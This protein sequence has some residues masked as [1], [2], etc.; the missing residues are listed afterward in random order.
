MQR[1]QLSFT[2]KSA[3]SHLRFV[4]SLKAKQTSFDKEIEQ[5]KKIAAKKG[6]SKVIKELELL[7]KNG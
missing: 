1:R 5:A 4:Q 7:E 2:P 6:D 3:T